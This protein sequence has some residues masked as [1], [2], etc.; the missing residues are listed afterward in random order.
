MTNVTAGQIE[1][2]R[3]IAED[4][5]RAVLADD[6]EAYRDKFKQFRKVVAEANGPKGE[7]G[8]FA[9]DGAGTA[10][11][12]ALEANPGDIPH[13]GQNGLFILNTVHGR[14]MV[15]FRS[16]FDTLCGFAFHAVD[17]GRDF[18]SETGFLSSFIQGL[19]AMPVNE[20]AEIAYCAEV[21]RRGLQ[22]IRMEYRSRR[23]EEMPAF[24]KSTDARFQG[25][26][27]HTSKEGQ[28]GFAF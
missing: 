25:V 12:T 20:A 1:A 27:L 4:F 6:D 16:G 23:S 21:E 26:P 11:V 14:V 9:P 15:Q 28:M 13:W 24:A 7:F 19:P 2:A 8:S 10:I 17:L 3:A 22:P 5:N 18:V